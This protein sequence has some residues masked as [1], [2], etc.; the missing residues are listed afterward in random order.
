HED[1]RS[2]SQ[3]AGAQPAS[4]QSTP[5]AAAAIMPQPEE[6]RTRKGVAPDI[7]LSV[8][9]SARNSQRSE[10]SADPGNEGADGS[11]SAAPSLEGRSGGDEVNPKPTRRTSRIRRNAENR[12][13]E[14]SG[15]Y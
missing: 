4:P 7:Q 5:P 13:D 6:K 2:P 14:P 10:S 15:T 11:K 9:P 12:D 3:S 8:E 1:S